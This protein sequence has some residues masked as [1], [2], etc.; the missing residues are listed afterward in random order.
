ML[1]RW[2]T[3]S[4][5]EARVGFSRVLWEEVDSSFRHN[6]HPATGPDVLCQNLQSILTPT[7]LYFVHCIDTKKASKAVGDSLKFT[8]LKW[9]ALD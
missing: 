4:Q 8:L 7:R 9:Q 5:R 3:V 1:E 2:S 6:Y